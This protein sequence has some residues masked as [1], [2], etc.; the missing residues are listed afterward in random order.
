MALELPRG[1]GA[2]LPRGLAH[3]GPAPNRLNAPAARGGGALNT[4]KA[5]TRTRPRKPPN[6]CDEDH[7]DL[8]QS[9][10]SRLEYECPPP[11][12][13]G[14]CCSGPHF[15]LTRVNCLSMD[16]PRFIGK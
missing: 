5:V 10:W 6:R 7:I 13:V 15:L 3:D 12:L 14:N 16:L 4:P 9:C 8:V 1:S 11:R 2:L